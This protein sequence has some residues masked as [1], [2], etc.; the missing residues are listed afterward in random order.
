MQKESYYSI[1]CDILIGELHIDDYLLSLEPEFLKWRQEWLV[2][3]SRMILY[4]NLETPIYEMDD[5]EFQNILYSSMGRIISQMKA[6]NK[7]WLLLQWAHA[8]FWEILLSVVNHY[9][10]WVFQ[11]K[12]PPPELEEMEK[13][14]YEYMSYE[15]Y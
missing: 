2:E 3:L 1:I 15:K 12:W 11:I 14:W 13:R 4:Q 5:L 7:I 8:W 10:S 9:E 6:S